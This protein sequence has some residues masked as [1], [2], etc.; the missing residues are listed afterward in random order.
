MARELLML[1]VTMIAME[2]S[3]P[4]RIPLGE[5]V[6]RA[7][8]RC[9]MKVGWA[10]Y[11]ALLALR[12]ENPKPRITYLDGAVELM[13][14]SFD[15]ERISARIGGLIEFFCIAA[16]IVI[17]PAGSY[18]ISEHDVEAGAEAD[19][20]YMFGERKSRPDLAIEVVWTS[21]GLDK[22]EIYRRLG[23]GEVWFWDE[24]RISV[25]VLGPSGYESRE[26]SVV[27]PTI[28]LDIVRELA[29]SSHTYNDAMARMLAFAKSLG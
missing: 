15:H 24:S 19:K 11:E 6:P 14:T 22:L 21:G 3:V 5:Y 20:C 28:D 17:E 26:R 12:G 1:G 13:T 16:G 18:T 27:L 25:H 23:V 2:V 9:V 29:D 10:G 4:T 8:G 7:D